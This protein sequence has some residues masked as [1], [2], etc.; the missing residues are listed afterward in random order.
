MKTKKETVNRDEMSLKDFIE[1]VNNRKHSKTWDA[2][3]R[4]QGA[5]ICTDP[6]LL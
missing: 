2:M 3:M 1:M 6:N 4:N 5:I